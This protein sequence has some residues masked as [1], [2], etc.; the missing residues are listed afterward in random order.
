MQKQ[1]ELAA[2]KA[3]ENRKRGEAFLAANAKRQGIVTLPSG[4]QYEI[5]QEGTG[6]KPTTADTVVCHYRGT[7]IDGKEFDS[8]YKRGEPAEFPVT[9]VIKGWTEALQ[10]MKVGAK[11]KLYIPSDLAYGRSGRGGIGPNETLLFEIELVGIK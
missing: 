11:W 9:G 7:F 1:R 2:E 4:L 10:L 8:S 6:L 5:V 3:P